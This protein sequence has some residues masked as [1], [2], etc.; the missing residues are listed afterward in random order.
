[1]KNE[2]CKS[3]GGKMSMYYGLWCPKCDKPKINTKQSLNLIKALYHLEA[4]GN[5][6]LK[7]KVWPILCDVYTFSNDSSFD[8][9]LPSDEEIAEDEVIPE[10]AEL[11]RLVRDTWDI[12]K[13]SISMEVS[14]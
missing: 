4:I 12:K 7:D 9:Y 8:F 5:K 13:D 11:V 1:V 10:I 2:T 14:W 6:G 3:C